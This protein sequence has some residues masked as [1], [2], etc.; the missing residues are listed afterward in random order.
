M[1]STNFMYIGHVGL[2]IGRQ[3]VAS[4]SLLITQKLSGTVQ[5][6]FFCCSNGALSNGFTGLQ[7]LH[8]FETIICKSMCINHKEDKEVF[9]MALRIAL[10][11]PSAIA[12]AHA[13]RFEATPPRNNFKVWIIQSS[14]STNHSGLRLRMTKVVKNQNLAGNLWERTDRC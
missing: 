6:T 12:T 2:G 5:N 1:I 13:L 7:G 10:L 11:L 9:G 3:N 8:F 14:K 4:K